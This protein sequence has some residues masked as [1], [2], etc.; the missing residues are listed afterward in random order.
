LMRRI[1]V[2]HARHN[3]RRT[4]SPCSSAW[5]RLRRRAGRTATRRKTTS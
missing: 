2:D 5:R 4:A 1:L 3:A